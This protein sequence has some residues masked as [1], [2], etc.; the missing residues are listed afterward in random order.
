[1]NVLALR[2]AAPLVYAAVVAIFWAIVPG[3]AALSFTIVGGILLGLMY[4]LTGRTVAASGEGR[5]RNRNRG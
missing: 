4:A 5:N 2:R 1:V 3:G